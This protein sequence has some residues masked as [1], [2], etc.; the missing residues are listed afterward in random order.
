MSCIAADDKSSYACK[1]D[2]SFWG[3]YII[4]KTSINSRNQNVS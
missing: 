1:Y 4:F 3:K 2:L